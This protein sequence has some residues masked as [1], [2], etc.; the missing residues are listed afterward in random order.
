MNPQLIHDIE[1]VKKSFGNDAVKYRLDSHSTSE[2]F[3]GKHSPNRIFDYVLDC[4]KNS[5]V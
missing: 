1:R 5:F 2:L 4:P 3:A